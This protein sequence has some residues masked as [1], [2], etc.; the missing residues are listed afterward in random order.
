M[1]AEGWEPGTVVAPGVG[2]TNAARLAF[3]AG[4]MGWWRWNPAT[5]TVDWSPELEQLYGLPPGSFPGDFAA[6]SDGIHPDDRAAV[7]ATIDAAVDRRTDFVVE[8]RVVRPD[9]EIRWI[10]GR[11][12]P[13]V[14]EQGAIRDWV[15]I[16]IDVTVRVVRDRELRDREIETSIAFAAGRMGS[17][18]WDTATARGVWS[19]EL[20]A[21][22]GLPR[23]GFDGTWESFVGPILSDDHDVLRTAVV[24]AVA[25]D[26]DFSVRYRVRRRDGDVRWVETRGRRLTETDWV[27][28]TI[29]VTELTEVEVEMRSARDR[30]EETV[31]R[32]DALLEHAS[33][34]FAFVDGDERFVRVNEVFAQVSG[35]TPQDHV[36]V[37]VAALVPALADALRGSGPA[38]DTA[39]AEREVRGAPA[40]D[41]SE[42]H[43][44]VAP[45]PV[46]SVDGRALGAGLMAVDITERKRRER[47]MR[48][49]AAASDLLSE[50]G[51]PD[52]LDRMAAIA[53][54]EFADM[55]V[56]YV[57]PRAGMPRRFAVSHLS[58]GTQARLREIEARW[59]QDLER[60]RAA[61]GDT[62]ALLVS[63]VTTAQRGAFTSGDPEEIAFAEEHGAASVIIVP[64][65][66]ATRELGQLVLSYTDASGRRYRADDIELATAIGNRFAQLIENEYLA[67]EAERAQSRLDLLAAVSELLTVELDTRARLEAIVE[68]VLPTFADDCAVYLPT[69]TGDLELAAYATTDGTAK[70]HVGGFDAA[71][72]GRDSDAPP[73]VVM[74]TGEALLIEEVTPALV[75]RLGDQE[76]AARLGGAVDVSS[77]IIAPLRSGDVAIGI[78]AFGLRGPDRTY[79]ADD[80]SLAEEIARRVAPAVENALRYERQSATAE[81][82]QRSLLPTQLE[83]FVG[84]DLAARY[85]PGS[86]GIRIGGDWYDAVPL[87][88]GR[89]MV[90]IGDVVGHGIP[91]ATWMGRLRTLVQFCALD[92]LDP[93]GVLERLNDYCFSAA[94]S[95]MATVLV[96]IFDPGEATI[97]FASAG[98]PPLVVQRA[99]GAVDVVWD[100]RG[101]PLCAIERVHF[102]SARIALGP[103]DLLA[104]YTDG[105]V[106]RRGESFDVGVGRLVDALRTRP[107]DLEAAADHLTDQLL[108]PMRPADD[109]ALLLVAPVG[110]GERLDLTLASDAR[111]LAGLRRTLRN[112][113][114]VKGM[115]PEVV[116]ELVVAVNEVAGNAIEHA[117]GPGDAH[118]EVRAHTADGVVTIEVVDEGRWRP[119]VAGNRGRGLGIAD[120]LT[121]ELRVDR[122]ERGTTVRMVRRIG[123]AG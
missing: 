4:G 123:G 92:G 18:R 78:V 72:H 10:E 8:H 101:P 119:P 31:A 12:A 20:E 98:H 115:E 68:V 34:G 73:A 112:W 95:D 55:C 41:G 37:P 56:L 58:P 97:D 54:P 52:G 2:E 49:T 24:D 107:S 80:R 100:G 39:G 43:W 50:S 109:V 57:P 90:A 86:D 91:A 35:A 85:V 17:W 64:L 14:D 1:N 75:A 74:R 32:L 99:T 105:L 60:T 93:S 108:G 89:L 84:A 9:G 6:Y 15:G 82:L 61:V 59:P 69:D 110:V 71:R 106:E 38:D 81:A 16:A 77:L 40:P 62:D 103:G 46:R 120:Q 11:G 104:L 76:Y 47:I 19:P 33:F 23:G 102:E 111:E 42:R 121:D 13:V 66:S 87:P 25:A 21:L 117:Y 79:Q 51:R 114:V 96:A 5:G 83:R 3:A 7:L 53:V 45:Y 88:S 94:G 30:L 70:A 22:V 29:D 118:F 36:G 122:S 44:L 116:S 48:L 63:E 113:L 28:V 67:R 65:R 27:G 26:R